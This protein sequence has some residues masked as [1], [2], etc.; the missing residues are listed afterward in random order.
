MYYDI[1]VLGLVTAVVDLG[2]NIP[3]LLFMMHRALSEI[4]RFKET[5]P[6]MINMTQHPMM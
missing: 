6:Q 2:L 5:P 1:Y 3:I 4:D